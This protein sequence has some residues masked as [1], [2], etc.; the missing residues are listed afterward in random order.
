MAFRLQLLSYLPFIEPPARTLLDEISD[1]RPQPPRSRTLISGLSE[2]CGEGEAPQTGRGHA[3]N[4]GI[5]SS[6]STPNMC[7]LYGTFNINWLKLLYLHPF[8]CSPHV[9]YIGASTLIVSET[10]SY[11]RL[12]S[13]RG[14]LG[15]QG[16]RPAA[17]LDGAHHRRA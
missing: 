17:S 10:R 4:S 3:H 16:R 11:K 2:A 12:P 14:M 15:S 7:A 6:I 9:R 8:Q 13:G 5:E 1:I